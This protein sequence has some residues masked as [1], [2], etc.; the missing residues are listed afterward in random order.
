MIIDG[1]G[2]E[3]SQSLFNGKLLVTC[4]QDSKVILGIGFSGRGTILV[5]G[6][7]NEVKLGDDATLNGEISV[8]GSNNRVSI[9]KNA[10]IRGSILVK[11]DRQEVVIGDFTTFQSVYLLCQEG[12]NVTIGHSCMLSRDIEI[13]TTDAHSVIE[14]ES[15]HR[16][17]QPASVEIGNHVWI[18]VGALISKGSVIPEDSIVGAHSFVNGQ[19]R[20]PNVIVAGSP[21]RVVKTG[22]T[23]SRSRKASFSEEEITSWRK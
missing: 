14:L 15:R 20:Q 16:I 22:V 18:G 9:G 1:S 7:G 10:V 12:C 17:N 8:Q 3:I 11:G 23:W 2:L 4:P 19:F 5:K 21:A 6:G 13:R